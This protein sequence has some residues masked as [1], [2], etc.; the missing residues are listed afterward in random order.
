MELKFLRRMEESGYVLG[1]GAA[2]NGE[3][4][5]ATRLRHWENPN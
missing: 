1:S 5:V 2:E 3:I 4:V